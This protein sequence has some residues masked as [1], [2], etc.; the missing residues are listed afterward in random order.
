MLIYSDCGDH[1]AITVYA[2]NRYDALIQGY[3]FIGEDYKLSSNE[4]R[5]L[6]DN[7]NFQR[8]CELFN[9]FSGTNLIWLSE[10]QNPFINK[11]DSIT[12]FP[13]I[14]IECSTCKNNIEYPPPHTCD[15]CTSLDDEMCCMW[16]AKK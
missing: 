8:A 7:S 10:V 4:M 14:K 6:F 15:V 12:E 1:T 13:G 5:V 16:E 2:E 3:S 9:I 11:L